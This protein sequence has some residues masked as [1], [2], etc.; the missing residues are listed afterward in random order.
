[1]IALGS[2]GLRFSFPTRWTRR[3][4]IVGAS[5]IPSSVSW[6]LYKVSLVF[7]P[8]LPRG[9]HKKLQFQFAMILL[10]FF[11]KPSKL[12]FPSSTS[13]CRLLTLF[14]RPFISLKAVFRVPKGRGAGGGGGRSPGALK[15]FSVE[16]GAP[17]LRYLEPS[18]YFT[19]EPGALIKTFAA[20]PVAPN[21]KIRIFLN[22]GI[23]VI[24]CFLCCC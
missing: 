18:Y 21:I 13:F 14:F 9:F 3:N 1:M 22:T 4:S 6:K 11:L 7:S 2:L 19:V 5:S 16:P 8:C 17:S 24:T 15:C 23:P 12:D 10:S 20:E